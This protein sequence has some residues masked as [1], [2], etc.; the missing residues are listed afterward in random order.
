MVVGIVVFGR[1]VEVHA[2]EECVV[3]VGGEAVVHGVNGI[4]AVDGLL[5][6]RHHVNIAYLAVAWQE[7][8]LAQTEAL[9]FLNRTVAYVDERTV[10]IA[11]VL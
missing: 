6:A 5:L 4:L 8:V 2:V 7:S 10:S 11:E 1:D 9:I 3:E